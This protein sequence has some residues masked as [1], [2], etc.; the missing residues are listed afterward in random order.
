MGMR[1]NL[2]DV[3]VALVVGMMLAGCSPAQVSPTAPL[4]RPAVVATPT[5]IT[6]IPNLRAESGHI[7]TPTAESAPLVATA[8]TT[9]TTMS[10]AAPEPVFTQLTTGGCC[11]QPF[12]SPDNTR[13]LYIDKPSPS[14]TTGLWSVPISQPLV[15]PELY[16]ARIG[17]FNADMT[18][19]TFLQSGRTVVERTKDA[20][21]WVID[22]GG[23]RVLFSPD[24]AHLA[25]TV[26]ED[27]GNFDVR[28]GD[29]FLAG[30]DGSDPRKVAT[31]FGGGVQAWLSDS[32]HM[33]VGGKAKR[34][35][36]TST[37]S[38]LSL[39][40]GSLRRLINAERPRSIALAPGD[41]YIAYYISQARDET[42][43]GMYVLDIAATQAQ[44]QRADFFGA[45]R[46][47]SPTRLYYVPLKMG[48][49]SNELWRYDATTGQSTQIIAASADSPFKIGNGD[50]DVSK[51][52]RQI[53]YFN[54]RDHNIWL[55]TLPDAC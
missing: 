29:V 30:I 8:I 51:D 47:C 32:T 14:A 1:V 36:V 11:V 18:Y 15:A 16:S 50:W 55:A 13:V 45:Y 4:Q 28:R 17:P 41:R 12:F 19:N 46:W 22:N 27:S 44:P 23:R 21:Q 52:G 42:Q 24:G 3:V 54:G 38:I 5:Q 31:L 20:K 53:V 33:L 34:D 40:D 49:A 26:A 2:R 48:S 43:N 6:N 7:L 10:I 39:A 9:A 37:L 25:W 35:D